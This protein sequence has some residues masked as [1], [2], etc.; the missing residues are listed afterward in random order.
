VMSAS[1]LANSRLMETYLGLATDL[2]PRLIHSTAAYWTLILVALH[3]GL[4]TTII[5]GETARLLGRNAPT[6]PVV[7]ALWATL[8]VACAFGVY[9]AFDRDL[10]AKL[11]AIYSFDFWDPSFPALLFFAE[12]LAIIVV[13]ATLGHWIAKAAKRLT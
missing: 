6:R 7:L 10:L 2:V 8:G 3:V 11:F 5:A 13:H 4:H 9:A 1:G 12:Y